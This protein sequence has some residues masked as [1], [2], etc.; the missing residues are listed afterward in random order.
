M[1]RCPLGSTTQSRS[2]KGIGR[3]STGNSSPISPTPNLHTSPRMV[4]RIALYLGNGTGPHSPRTRRLLGVCSQQIQINACFGIDIRD[5][6]ELNHASTLTK[7]RVGLQFHC[8]L[9][10]FNS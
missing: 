9:S 2:S 7:I 8:P 3:I 10:S 4:S 5:T 6:V 1:S